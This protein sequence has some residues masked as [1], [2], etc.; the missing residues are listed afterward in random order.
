MTTLGGLVSVRPA[1]VRQDSSSLVTYA[2]LLFRCT[3]GL[4][5]QCSYND[6]LLQLL[7]ALPVLGPLLFAAYVSPVGSVQREFRCPVPTIR[8]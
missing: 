2:R 8:K 4:C 1:T 3:T 5:A 7:R 6:Q